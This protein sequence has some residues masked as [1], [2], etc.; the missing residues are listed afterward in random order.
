[1]Q[2][3]AKMALKKYVINLTSPRP[4]HSIKHLRWGGGQSISPCSSKV[5]LSLSRSSYS[6][7]GKSHIFTRWSSTHQRTHDTDSEL[8]FSKL[9]KQYESLSGSCAPGSAQINTRSSKNSIARHRWKRGWFAGLPEF[10]SSM[11]IPLMLD[12]FGS[13]PCFQGE[14]P[15]MFSGTTWL[16]MMLQETVLLKPFCPE[17]KRK[18]SVDSKYLV[19]RW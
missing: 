10:F 8:P 3:V 1:M 17:T 11:G 9:S 18:A 14:S 15:F 5:A 12:D 19:T 16:N 7:L 6:T 2:L 4:P 13:Q